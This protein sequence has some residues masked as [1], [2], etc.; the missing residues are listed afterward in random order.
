M[1]MIHPTG[2]L[3]VITSVAIALVFSCCHKD[4]PCATCPPPTKDPRTYS[5]TRD[6]LGD[7]T[8][9]S[10]MRGLWGSSAK[11]VYV[12]GHASALF[13][14]KIW[15]YD[16]ISWTDLTLKYIEAFPGEQ[17]FS[18]DPS[19]VFGFSHD[20]VWIVGRRDT[21]STSNVI[22]KGFVMHYDGT[23]WTGTVVQGAHSLFGIGGKS[24]LDLW[25]GGS[26]G[27]L[28]HFNGS[29][30]QQYN[31]PDTV[32]VQFVPG[33]IGSNVYALGFTH[34]NLTGIDYMSLLEW[35]GATWNVD[36]ANRWDIGAN[37]IFLTISNGEIYS[38]P[39]TSVRKRISTGA[40]QTLYNNPIARFVWLSINSSSNMFVVGGN[41]GEEIYNYN[42]QDW[43]RYPQFTNSNIE[44]GVVR[45][46]GNEVFVLG[47]DLTAQSSTWPRSYL[48]RA[49]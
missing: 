36:E 22:K 42:G 45:C 8:Y 9:Q 16:G 18:F 24:S 30:W 37:F 13:T 32:S 20:D 11:D 34:N 10:S 17:I 4:E 3:S 1:R 49:K 6:T 28:F 41:A 46:L 21:S 15:R 35:N 48:L 12:V 44:Y 27:L 33:V 26:D 2:K 47:E 14:G 38:A 29:T 23:K 31:I 19:D 40:W 7:G 43:Y 5:W 25:V 39:Y